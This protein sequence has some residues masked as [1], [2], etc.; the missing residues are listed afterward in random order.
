MSLY[1][2]QENQKLLWDTMNKTPQYQLYGQVNPAER[3]TWFH[4][5]ISQIY[6]SNKMRNLSLTDLQSLNRETVG[7]MV[8][9]LNQMGFSQ[10]QQIMVTRDHF[11]EKKQNDLARDYDARQKEYSGMLKLAPVQEIDFRI[12]TEAEGPIENMEELIKKQ[13]IERNM[14]VPPAS[15][16]PVS[17]EPVSLEPVSLEPVSLAPV[18]LAPVSLEPVSLE[19]VSLEP[20]SLEPGELKKKVTWAKDPTQDPTQDPQ[21]PNIEEICDELADIKNILL[22]LFSQIK[23]I[24]EF[25]IGPI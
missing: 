23:E 7:F 3:E 25:L 9:E 20:V 18:S 5:I 12:S 24:R 21:K 19:P 14:D 6:N 10:N 4:A 11:S 16:A 17:L 1:I 22:D 8:K 2:L 15:I 13:I